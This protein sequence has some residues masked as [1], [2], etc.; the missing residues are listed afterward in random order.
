MRK[1]GLLWHIAL[2]CGGGDT[3]G[4][5]LLASKIQ[6]WYRISL[7]LCVSLLGLS[8][9]IVTSL[10]QGLYSG[11]YLVIIPS[12]RPHLRPQALIKFPST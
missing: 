1:R 10:Q 7:G 11:P 12:Q 6:T 5:I 3:F 4:D 8:S 2:V 9:N